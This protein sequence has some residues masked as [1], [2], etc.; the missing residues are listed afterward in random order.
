MS[1]KGPRR[2]TIRKYYGIVSSVE[3]KRIVLG[4]HNDSID[5]LRG[6]SGQLYGKTTGVNSNYANPLLEGN[7]FY[8]KCDGSTIPP[9]VE[10]KKVTVWVYVKKYSFKSTFTHNKDQQI[11]GWN[12]M[13][14]KIEIG[15]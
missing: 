7:K 2:R 13:L 12:L 15:W 4:G 6:L 10:G 5:K 14:T 9:G 1:K 11:Q 3:S 8:V